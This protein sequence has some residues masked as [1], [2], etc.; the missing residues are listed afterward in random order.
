MINFTKHMKKI[1]TTFADNNPPLVKSQEELLKQAKLHFDG[2]AAF[3]LKDIDN[4]FFIKNKHILIQKRG[5]GYWL[6]KPY[7]IDK[8]LNMLNEGDFL[9]YMDSGTSILKDLT[10]LF[11]LCVKA[12]GILLFEN[13]DGNPYKEI[14]INRQ[15][16][17]EDCFIKMNCES[18][19]YKNGKQCTA[20]LQLYQKCKRS[21]NFVKEY[22]KYCEDEDIL[23]DKPNQ[24][25]KNHETFIDH[26]HD[27]SV[28]SLLAIKHSV[29]LLPSPTECGEGTRPNNCPY[30]TVL[31]H[32]RGL[33]YGRTS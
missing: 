12:G 22:L 1:L 15:W 18:T 31:W 10:P 2:Y 6:W 26:R 8:V 30:G 5:V 24:L 23:T 13:R 11:N 3:S 7:F 28:L 20:N 4:A 19:N 16:T 33:I 9:F 32:H 29:P 27:Q 21:V 25:G 17:K 14:W